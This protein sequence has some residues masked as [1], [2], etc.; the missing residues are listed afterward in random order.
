MNKII[1]SIFSIFTMASGF[2]AQDLQRKD[3]SQ[4]PRYQQI[5]DSIWNAP[6]D[7][8]NMRDGEDV[9]FCLT[10]KFANAFA[11]DP[12]VS[13]FIALQEAQSHGSES[14]VTD[15]SKATALYIPI[16]FHILHNNGPEHISDDQ[17]LD[18]L[19]ILNRDYALQ[20][21]DAN[22]VVFAFNA[23]NPSATS[24][25]TS[26]DIQF[27]LATIA[28]DGTCFP[29]VTHTVTPIATSAT[30]STQIMNAVINGNDVCTGWDWYNDNGNGRRYLN[31]FVTDDIANDGAA[32]YSMY[33]QWGGLDM[34]NGVFANHTYIGS[35][36]T[37]SVDRSRTLTHEVGHWLNLA[38]PWG[39]SNS[40]GESGNCSIDD[41]V[42]DTPTT[43]GVTACLLTNNSCSQ[44]NAY[45]GFDQ[46]D[47]VENYMDYSY[48]SK[49]FSAGQVTRMR[50]A[51]QGTAGERN[52]VIS[53]ANL[54]A[55][56]ADGNLYLCRA[57]FSA[58]KTTICAG[59]QV[60]YT[61]MSY[62]AVNG[63]TWNFDGGSPATSSSQNPVVT[64]NT[65]GLY[66][67]T[68]QSTDGTN[69]DMETKTSYIRVLPAAASLPFLE[70]FESYTALN[71]I[72]EWDVEDI[73]NNAKFEL[74]TSF[75][76]TG[77]KCARLMNFGQN[78]GNTDELSSAPVDLSGINSTTGVT[79]SFRYAYRKRSSSNIEYLKVF[80][81]KDCGD[82]WVQRKTVFGDQ[83]SSIVSTSSWSPSSQSD[84]TTVH[85]TNVT[86][87][88]WVNN[89]RYK[90]VFES[91][92][93]N[94]FY[95]DDI[96]IYAGSQSD[97]IVGLNEVGEFKGLSLYPNPADNEINVSFGLEAAQDVVLEV[98]D[99]T[100]KLVQSNLIKAN[101]GN[102]LV[103]LNTSDFAQGVYMLNITAGSKRSTL[104]FMVK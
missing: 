100:G 71:N 96:N 65:P 22:N 7:I 85:M 9:E 25:P 23:S 15:Q 8:N 56:G 94:N 44:D 82:S 17:V 64:Y 60:T 52:L 98:T 80:V 21:A 24:V 31:V 91:D 47:Q 20:N 103:M 62:N 14:T 11:N 32:A 69:N 43:A 84:W 58:D 42:N 59:E 93:G 89:F 16:V 74:E 67:V 29:G 97:Q 81:T 77:T 38:H 33:P 53:A 49:M 63:W 13:E 102:N 37:G 2:W 35:I 61:D 88:Y 50:Q 76:H 54:A 19:D 86:S 99:L 55:T 101:T 66:Q 3:V 4:L 68:L 79:L 72:V 51:A 87:T 34:D 39:S 40:P 27:R 90:F 70:T 78:A 57:E 36:G 28:P 12:E 75:G 48:C 104:R 5:K 30:S 10:Q 6:R 92:G 18:A 41:G 95:L 45:W 83:L 26:V 73:G 1:V 46:I